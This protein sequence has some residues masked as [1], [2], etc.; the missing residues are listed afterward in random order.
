MTLKG[1]GRETLVKWA[2]GWRRVSPLVVWTEGLTSNSELA[3]WQI[4]GKGIGQEPRKGKQWKLILESVWAKGADVFCQQFLKDSHSVFHSRCSCDL[5]L[6]QLALHESTTNN[7]SIKGPLSTHHFFSEPVQQT[8]PKQLPPEPIFAENNHIIKLS[9]AFNKTKLLDASLGSE[10]EFSLKK[11]GVHAKE[12][13]ILHTPSKWK[14][15]TKKVPVG[16]QA[17]PSVTFPDSWKPIDVVKAGTSTVQGT[18]VSTGIAT[19]D[20]SSLVRDPLQ[21]QTTA[22][23][24]SIPKKAVSSRETIMIKSQSTG[25]LKGKRPTKTAPTNLGSSRPLPPEKVVLPNTVSNSEASIT[26]GT[27]CK[28]KTHIVF[29]KVHKSASS[30]VMNILFRFGETRNLT[31]ALPINGASQLYYPYYFTAGVVEG[32]SSSK[33]AKF[34]IMC[35]HMRFFRPEVRSRTLVCSRY[36][37]EPSLSSRMD[38][39]CAY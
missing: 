9:N 2:F 22:S 36:G 16:D 5:K 1:K 34:N 35:H 39:F 28:P 26:Q 33:E 19:D 31:F 21:N 23:P 20:P 10:E 17:V 14:H 6:K 37:A 12:M 11:I 4:D 29:L 18:E 25:T 27:T 24:S 15:G 32:F 7:N 13:R 8:T 38:S 3:Q 30:T